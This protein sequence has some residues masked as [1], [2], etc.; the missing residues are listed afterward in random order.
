MA[1]AVV[2]LETPA[3]PVRLT[4]QGARAFDGLCRTGGDLQLAAAYS[5]LKRMP[6][7]AAAMVQKARQTMVEHSP[8][9]ADKVVELMK[10]DT[11]LKVS[12]E[13]ARR[14]LDVVGVKPPDGPGP[15]VN[16]G[17]GVF[18]SRHII[19]RGAPPEQVKA[20]KSEWASYGGSG[21]LIDLR[22]DHEIQ[23]EK[24]QSGE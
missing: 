7:V 11:S 6:G 12:F 8:M 15:Q 19:D 1:R 3:G 22:E 23:A 14:V 17:I 21:Y 24:V 20:I 16:I 5:G 2:T 10:Q 13:A 18:P 9:A 4:Q